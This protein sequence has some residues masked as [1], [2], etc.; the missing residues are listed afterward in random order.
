MEIR[1]GVKIIRA[2]VLFRISKGVIMPTFGFL[3]TKLALENDVIHLHLPQFDAAGLAIR[4]RL[5][6]KPTVIT[7]HCDLQMPKGILNW[8]ANQAVHFMNFVACLFAD[9]IVTYTQDYA[10]TFLLFEKIFQKNQDN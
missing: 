10:D 2:P 1:D 3:A 8:F 6:K 5:F 4:G 9:K 7:Y